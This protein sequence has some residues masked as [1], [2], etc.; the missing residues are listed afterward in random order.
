MK[1]LIV[2]LAMIAS[3]SAFAGTAFYKGEKLSGMNKICYYDY[4]GSEY[5]KTIRSHEVCPTSIRV[6]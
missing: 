6:R 3:A 4:L 2:L 5:V 1:K